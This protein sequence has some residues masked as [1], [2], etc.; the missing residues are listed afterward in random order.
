MA[1]HPTEVD[2]ETEGERRQFLREA[3]LAVKLGHREPA[4]QETWAALGELVGYLV[5]VSFRL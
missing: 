5:R 3:G 1:T 4:P 2:Q